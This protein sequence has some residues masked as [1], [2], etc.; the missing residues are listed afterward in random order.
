MT[1]NNKSEFLEQT[2]YKEYRKSMADLYK[3]NE[4]FLNNFILGISIL[5]FP[6][7]YNILSNG[8]LV[9]T[10]QYLLSLALLNF[11]LVILFGIISINNTIHACHNALNEESEQAIKL[12]EKA[13][14]FNWFRD[15]FFLISVVLTI[16]GI[17]NIFNG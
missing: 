3:E 5:A 1:E 13:S 6:F 11:S 16:I 12:F 17:L 4:K 2:E 15:Y 14:K 10:T 9:K 7:L 8:E